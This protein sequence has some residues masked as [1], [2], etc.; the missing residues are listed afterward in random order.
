MKTL[1]M[2]AQE[3]TRDC[4]T[5]YMLVGMPGSGKSTWAEQV[6]PELPVVSRDIIRAELGYTSG[7]NHKAVLSEEKEAAVTKAEYEKMKQYCKAK[8][9]F[10]IDDTNI[11]KYRKQ[12]IDTLKSYGAYIIGVQFNTPLDVCISR[13]KGQIPDDV[14]NRI[15]A[16]KIDLDPTEV[17]EI[18]EAR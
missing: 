17:D 16:K 14:M 4:A 15:Y 7:P 12:L 10:I 8:E 18:I 6:H 11:S 5:V 13:R 9:D 1:N 3:K 2:L